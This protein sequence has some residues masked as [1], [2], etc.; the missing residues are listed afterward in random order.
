MSTARR[1]GPV[2][3]LSRPGARTTIPGTPLAHCPG[4]RLPPGPAAGTG[5]PRRPTGAVLPICP[6]YLFT[7]PAS[8]ARRRHPV[9]LLCAACV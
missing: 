5:T 6:R 2:P 3:R 8:A 1:Q 4:P 9:G 7:P